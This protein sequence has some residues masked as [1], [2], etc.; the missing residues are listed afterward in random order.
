MCVCVSQTIGI[1][2]KHV[3][4]MTVLDKNMDEFRALTL[5]AKIEVHGNDSELSSG[6]YTNY[7]KVTLLLCDSY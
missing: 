3:T 5:I 7:V 1:L 6:T 2:S 4:P